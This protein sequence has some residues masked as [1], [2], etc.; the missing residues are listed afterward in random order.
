MGLPAHFQILTLTLGIWFEPVWGLCVRS[1]HLEYIY[2]SDWLIG[3]AHWLFLL[4]FKRFFS[5]RGAICN[6]GLQRIFKYLTLT[7]GFS[8]NLVCPWVS[9]FNRGS[10]RFEPVWGAR[11]TVGNYN[12]YVH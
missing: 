1:A 8:R 11:L 4:A 3:L 10:G 2:A 6:M 9:G 7:L 5:W 12:L